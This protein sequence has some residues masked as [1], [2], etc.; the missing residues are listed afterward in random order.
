MKI[1]CRWMIVLAVLAYLPVSLMASPADLTES[2]KQSLVYLEISSS[3]Y[4]LYQPWK[5]SPVSNESGFGCAVGPY[6]VLTTAENVM[7]A[8]F[9]KTKIYGQNA[10]I[11]ATVKAVDYEYNLCLL[12]LDK[13]ELK[14]PLKPIKFTETFPKKESLQ[15]YWL[16]SAGH[17]TTARSS[18]DRAQMVNSDVSF[19]KNLTF[20]TSNTS[21]PFGDGEVCCY[22][23]KVIGVACWGRDSDSGI[24]PAESI[25]RFISQFKEGGY[26]GFGSVGFEVY[27]LLDPTMRRYLQFPDDVENGVYVSAVYAIGTGS[28]ELK[29]GDVILSID[30]NAL[31]AYGR[32]NHP[33]YDRIS[34][35]DL[36]LSS[37][38][39]G[40]IKFN[41]FRDG[42]PL[43]L[44]IESR[45]IKSDKMLVPYYSCGEQPEYVVIG[46]FVFQAMTRDY[47]KIW[48][49][50]WS[51]K[52]PS[53][54]YHYYRDLACKPTIDRQDVI[55][56][57]YV[58]P[59]PLN[60][61][62]QQ[63]TR[64][65]VDT[66]NGKKVSSI[67]EFMSILNASDDRDFYEITFEMDSPAVI[68]PKSQL[69][70]ANMQVAQIY[71]VQKM[72]N[73]NQ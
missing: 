1:K 25:N 32:Y 20:I 73:L 29:P 69:E 70:A 17:L 15:T 58:L 50:D 18:L 23:K 27:T 55:V 37:P 71:G 5:Q 35:E 7:D 53:H 28:Q 21:R 44:E 16:S 6:E 67:S 59:I 3:K 9:L 52:V 47:L 13:N 65:V 12:E 45:A 57:S 34:F 39:G 62:Y 8:T 54:L 14:Q 2:M 4:D 26:K 11:S 22:G 68:I 33:I 72:S 60:Q 42:K 36:I 66:L 31:D 56:L 40:M 51:G 19:A 46:G 30:G 10:F 64:I 43:L 48:G 24:I 61:G 41:I 49:S 38:V 63:L